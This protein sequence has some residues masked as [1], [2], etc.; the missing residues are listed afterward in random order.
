MKKII[1]LLSDLW[2]RRACTLAVFDVEMMRFRVFEFSTNQRPNTYLNMSNVIFHISERVCYIAFDQLQMEEIDHQFDAFIVHLLNNVKCWNNRGVFSLRHW[3]ANRLKYLFHS[4]WDNTPA[5]C[6]GLLAQSRRWYPWTR[7]EWRRIGGF[8]M[9]FVK[10]QA[11]CS[12]G[13]QSFWIS[14]QISYIVF[15][16][17]TSSRLSGH[18]VNSEIEFVFHRMSK[19]KS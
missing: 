15:S 11:L 19:R 14:P 13:S 1:K 18:Q 3:L 16:D 2:N 8:W 7:V 17:I 5:D 12:G 9:V 4:Y 6:I 10:S